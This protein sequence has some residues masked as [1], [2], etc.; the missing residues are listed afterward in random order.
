MSRNAWIS[1]AIFVVLLALVFITREDKVSVGMRALWLP[2]IEQT[3]IKRI[4]VTGKHKAL[5]EKS[6]ESWTVADPEKPDAK[7]AVDPTM[8]EAALSA[9][10]E[11]DSGSFVTG[12]PE[13]HDELEISDDKGL[14]VRVAQESGPSLDAVFGRMAKGGGNYLR[15]FGTDEVFLGKGRFASTVS[16]DAKSWRKRK[17]VSAKVEE[18]AS[19]DVTPVTGE[20][21]TIESFEEGEGDT[22]KTGWRL[23]AGTALPEGFLIDEALIKRVATSVANLRAAEFADDGAKGLGGTPTAGKVVAKTKA[24]QT[25][26]ISFGDED[27]KKRRYTKIDGDEQ[28]YLVSSFSVVNLTKPKL[29]LRDLTLARFDPAG[30]ERV[31]V[32][33][34]KDTVVVE[35]KDGAWTLVSPSPA[36]AGYE[37]D[38]STVEA[39]LSALA[40]VKGQKRFESAPPESGL[41]KPGV[42]VTLTLAGGAQKRIAF[43]DAVPKKEGETGNEVFVQGTEESV[44]YAV[45][46]WQ[47]DRYAKPLDLFKKVAPPPG[48]P[49]GG[50]G[51]IPGMENLPPDVRAKL[52]KQLQQQGMPG[53]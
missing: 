27:D 32:K 17:L 7:F 38:G 6:G 41:N 20:P 35:K 13:K 15:L 18:L 34:E 23:Q 1:V 25:I 36:P 24:G 11:L 9:F 5:L 31:Q 26:A 28:V 48:P 3:A 19:I 53:R 16:K 44:P 14:R 30:V 33:G 12:R 52:M 46:K 8:I 45:G 43:G 39:K 29:E 49:G 22:K 42:V 37:F 21:Y 4:E 10:A 50:A 51:G 47:R 40:R 2:K